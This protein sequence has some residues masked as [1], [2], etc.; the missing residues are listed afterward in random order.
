MV[1]GECEDWSDTTIVKRGVTPYD[2]WKTDILKNMEDIPLVQKE[3]H[4]KS[5][6]YYHMELRRKECG[7]SVKKEVKGL[8]LKQRESNRRDQQ[9][10]QSTTKRCKYLFH[11]F[12]KTKV[13]SF[14]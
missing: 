14:M 3:E 6:T 11:H 1:T 5:W 2:I 4:K 7:G 13:K 12:H 9:Q 10:L 8:L